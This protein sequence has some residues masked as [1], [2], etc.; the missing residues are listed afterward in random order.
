MERIRFVIDK[1]TDGQMDGQ[2]ERQTGENLSIFPPR[3]WR[4]N[5]RLQHMN[6]VFDIKSDIIP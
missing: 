1:K 4:P 5:N 6:L 3:R 2:V